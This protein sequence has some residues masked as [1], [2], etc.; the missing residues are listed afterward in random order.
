MWPK[1]QTSDCGWIVGNPYL[2][3]FRVARYSEVTVAIHKST[4]Q[5]GLNLTIA[6]V[7][8]LQR[9]VIGGGLVQCS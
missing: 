7:C 1:T 8:R 3:A 6:L 2:I 5:D 9:Y 4:C